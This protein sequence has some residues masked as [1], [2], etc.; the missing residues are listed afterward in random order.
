MT[1]DRPLV[2]INMDLRPNPR[3]SGAWSVLHTG[4]FDIILVAEGLPVLL[5]PFVKE[6][7]IAPIFD[8]LD[9]LILTGGE[10]L[11]PRKQGLAPHPSVRLVPERREQ[12]DRLLCKLAQQRKIPVL[13]IGL[14]MQELNVCYGGGLFMH[15]P[16]DLP[17]AMPHRDPQGG[18][19]RH[20]V[21]MEKGSMLEDIYGE[22]EVLVTSYHH[23]AVRKVAPGFRVAATAPDGVI[24]AIEWEGEDW[25][26]VG[27]QWHPENEGHISLDMQLIEAF[28]SAAVKH[29]S[30]RKPLHVLAKAG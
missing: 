21:K 9:A 14:G 17:R 22:D 25:F 1:K 13:G 27:V 29:R 30:V 23:Q 26:C 4:Y 19:H 10:D 28:V 12:A 2:G 20:V 18:L 5:P 15:I 24:E 3:G 8:R 7:D 11:D 6:Q 16:E